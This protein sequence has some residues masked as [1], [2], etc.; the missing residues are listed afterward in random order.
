MSE[1]QAW[2]PRMLVVWVR[3]WME[4][5]LTEMGKTRRGIDWEVV[6]DQI[7]FSIEVWDLVRHVGGDFF[8]AVGL[9]IDIG[10][11]YKLKTSWQMDGVWSCRSEWN[12]LE[13]ML[14]VKL[15]NPKFTSLQTSTHPYK[16]TVEVGSPCRGS[17]VMNLTSNHEDMVWSLA[18][19]SG[20]RI[21]H[22]CEL[23]F[24]SQMQ[25]ESRIAVAV[26]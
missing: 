14:W 10:W 22:C 9:R 24:R 3:A 8:L 19:L 26:V 20:L 18:P 7:W 2:S 17:T 13:N 11:L 15:P 25:L 21:R 4:L 6:N 12:N 16:R 5:P 23:Q 1:H